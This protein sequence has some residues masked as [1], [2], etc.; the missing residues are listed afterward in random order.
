[1]PEELLSEQVQR[2]AVFAAI[3]GSLWTF[4]LF[5][6]VTVLPAANGT[7]LWNWRTIPVEIAGGLISAVL[8]FVF[9]RLGAEPGRSRQ[10][11]G[12]AFMLLNAVGISALNAWG[13]VLPQAWRDPHLVDRG[14]HPRLLDDCARVAATHADGVA[15]LA[16]L[17][18]PLAFAIADLAGLPTPP[19]DRRSS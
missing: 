1:M 16:A 10:N 2:L 7:G 4:A 8:W 14:A 15:W 5:L 9:K 18:D 6:D 17:M 3:A 13:S 12:L 11:A 19:L